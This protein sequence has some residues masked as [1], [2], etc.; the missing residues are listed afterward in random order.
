MTQKIIEIAI[1]FSVFFLPGYISQY[2]L[3]ADAQA[4]LT[5]I[6]CT[7]GLAFVAGTAGGTLIRLTGA[8]SEIYEDQGDFL[9]VPEPGE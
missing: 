9:G 5:G 6:V 4:Q 3:P 7:V 1:L 8:K 2:N